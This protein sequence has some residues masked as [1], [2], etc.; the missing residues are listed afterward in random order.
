MKIGIISAVPEEI[1]TIHDDLDF[2]DSVIH[3]EREFHLGKYKSID[4]VLVISRVGKVAASITTSALIEKFQVDRIIFTGLAGAV[5]KDLNRGDIVLSQSTYQHDLDARPLCE[6]Q[7][8]VPLTN[9]RLFETKH[10]DLNL[11]KVAINNFLSQLIN[12]V[13]PDELKRLAIESPKV[14]IGIIA[15]GD[16][17]IENIDAQKNLSIDGVQALAVEMEGAAVAQVCAEYNIP[18]KLIRT[19]SDKANESAHVSLQDFS[20]KVASHYSSGIVQELLK[21]LV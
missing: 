7:F 20:L 21:L 17:F 19:I 16:V 6:K 2:H 11:A 15:T 8:E 13:D 9:R 5:S 12:Y 10:E 14:H 4:L 3:A 1:Q 18:Y